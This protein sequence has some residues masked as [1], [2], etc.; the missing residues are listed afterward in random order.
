MGVAHALPN[1]IELVQARDELVALSRL[2]KIDRNLKRNLNLLMIIL[3][4]ET[5][6]P[7]HLCSLKRGNLQL[8]GDILETAGHDEAQTEEEIARA[9]L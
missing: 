6:T 4:L 5:L 9:E 3:I 1:N 2:T 7:L 8:L